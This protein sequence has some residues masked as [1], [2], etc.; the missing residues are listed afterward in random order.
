MSTAQEGNMQ[1]VRFSGESIERIGSVFD[2]AQLPR[3]GISD[4]ANEPSLFSCD[5]F[6]AIEKG[7]P[8]THLILRTFYES[9]EAIERFTRAKRAGLRDV[10]DVRVQRLMPG[11][12]PSIPGWHCDAVPRASYSSQPDFSKVNPA[13]YHFT[14]IL[15]TS[16]DSDTRSFRSS[17]A[18]SLTQFTSLDEEIEF[19]DQESIYRQLHRHIESSPN[20]RVNC[21]PGALY[22]F[23]TMVPHRTMPTINRGWR[24]FF[25]MSM[26]HAPPVANGVTSQQQVYLLSEENGW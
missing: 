17:G 22:G 19:N 12:Y 4:F 23:S 14:C 6:S 16:I 7:G 3:F 8:L 26:Y 10:V 21:E 1:K 18:T 24:L 5:F 20:P 15:D 13:S 11:M 25:R 9:A 2:Q